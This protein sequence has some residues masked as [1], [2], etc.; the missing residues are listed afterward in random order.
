MNYETFILGW[1]G[2][3]LPD[4][5]SSRRGT[6][7]S[8]HHILVADD[9]ELIRQLVASALAGEGF[10]VSVA[11]DGEEAWDALHHEHYDLLLTDNEMPRLRGVKLIERMRQEGLSLPVIMASGTFAFDRGRTV[12]ELHLAAVLPKP[13]DLHELVD[14][15][16]GVLLSASANAPAECGSLPRRQPNP[17]SFPHHN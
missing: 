2:E 4:A 5:A 13:F 6:N 14:T 16:R 15:I 10:E 17:L 1:P 9:D 8:A 11:A 7:A 3:G 12:P